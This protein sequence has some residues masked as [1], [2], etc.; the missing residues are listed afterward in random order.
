VRLSWMVALWLLLCLVTGGALLAQTPEIQDQVET[1]LWFHR[2]IRKVEATVA[3]PVA[4]FLLL[5]AV[6]LLLYGAIWLWKS[7]RA[8]RE[9]VGRERGQPPVGAD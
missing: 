4:L 2:F 6:G 8:A 3:P 7:R 1:E 9:Q 5:V